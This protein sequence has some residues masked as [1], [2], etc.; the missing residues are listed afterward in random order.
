MRALI[1]SAAVWATACSDVNLG[2][3]ADVGAFM[4]PDGS[5]RETFTFDDDGSQTKVDVLFIVDNSASMYEEQSKL[6]AALS[7]FINSIGRIDWQIAI[8]TTDVSDGPYGIKGSILPFKGIG[9]KILNKNVPNYAD[10]FAQTVVRDELLACKNGGTCPSTDE[11]PLQALVYAMQKKDTDNA[12]FFRPGADLA[13]V[14]LS[15]EDEG[16][17]GTNAISANSVV[18]TFSQTFGTSKTLSGYGII[19]KPGDTA[20]YNAQVPNGGSYGSFASSLAGLTNGVTGSIC[21]NDFGPALESIGNRVRQ[22]SQ[23]VTL[24]YTP[25]PETVQLIMV[26]F[27]SSVTWE[28]AGNTI[29]F[30]K[31]PKKGTRVDVVY[32][33]QH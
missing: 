29:K 30:S 25:T 21:D 7:S 24:M 5:Q 13:V 31:P 8:T 10:V 18:T 28:V 26:P 19:I 23:S 6:G 4:M 20:C 3:G 11:R 1:A 22:I 15:D 9:S 12:G 27:D 14:I 17:N 16:S 2:P 33:P 32:L